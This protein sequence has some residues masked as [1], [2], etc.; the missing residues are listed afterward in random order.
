MK[1]RLS[2]LFGAALALLGAACGGETLASTTTISQ[3]T[4]TASA[5]ATTTTTTPSTTT[6]T[7]SSVF[8]ELP[9]EAQTEVSD[10]CLYVEAAS[11]VEAGGS[12]TVEQRQDAPPSMPGR[13]P[14]D[15]FWLGIAQELFPSAE[16]EPGGLMDRY[17]TAFRNANEETS[18]RVAEGG[19]PVLLQSDETLEAVTGLYEWC[20]DIGWSS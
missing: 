20:L 11:N 15:S 7:Q 13:P 8:E 14:S 4:T 5:V 9:A 17:I 12:I 18:E 6:A 10:V 16:L 2:L 3:A 19:E 1:S